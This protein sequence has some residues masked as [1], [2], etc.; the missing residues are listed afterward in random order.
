MSG[1]ELPDW[2]V[3][4]VTVTLPKLDASPSTKG[5]QYRVAAIKADSRFRSGFHAALERIEDGILVFGTN[6]PLKVDPIHLAL[7]K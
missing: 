2:L 6:G 3:E 4:G 5:R 1:A 7:V